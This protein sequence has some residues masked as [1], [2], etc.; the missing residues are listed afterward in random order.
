MAEDKKLSDMS[1]KQGMIMGLSWGIALVSIIALIIVMAGG[2]PAK[3]DSNSNV[4][5]GNV[6][7]NQ[8]AD[9][10]TAQVPDE[11]TADV[12]KLSPVTDQDHIRGN[13]DAK[14]TLIVISDFQCPYCQRHEET[15][16]QVVKDYGNKVR[17]VWRNFPLTSIHPYAQKAAEAAECAGDQNKFWEM[18][19][20]LFENQSALTVDNLKGY[21]K[22]LG[23][24]ETTFSSCL[25]SGKYTEKVNKQAAEA[26]ASGVSGTPGT[27]VN[28]ELVKGAY[29]FDTFKQLI[30]QA[31]Q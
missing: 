7:T 5:A 15:L 8:A 13:K 11:P 2:R 23:L 1:G 24:N 21:A 12:S 14:V 25:D 27:F 18:H 6:N 9:D 22:G 29:P 3:K 26:Q 4:A 28:S 20:K 19:D 17:I 30:D 10:P 16:K 31:L